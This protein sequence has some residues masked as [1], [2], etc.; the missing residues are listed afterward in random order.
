MKSNLD[1]HLAITN[2]SSKNM[3]VNLRT[4]HKHFIHI[5]MISSI[6]PSFYPQVDWLCMITCKK[7]VD[8]ELLPIIHSPL[9]VYLVHSCLC[10]AFKSWTICNVHYTTLN[11]PINLSHTHNLAKSQSNQGLKLLLS[12]AKSVKIVNSMLIYH[13]F[14]EN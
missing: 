6:I 7:T 13:R 12:D 4:R 2:R 11:I 14:Q 1:M 9:V 8:D 10:E 5:D 3:R